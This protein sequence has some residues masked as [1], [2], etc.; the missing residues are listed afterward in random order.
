MA[1]LF[2]V[3]PCEFLMHARALESLRVEIGFRTGCNCNHGVSQGDF[4][5]GGVSANRARDLVR[6][7]R[8]GDDLRVCAI[9]TGFDP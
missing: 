7:S 2:G 8:G 1:V 4:S 5:Y 9:R 6:D 3:V